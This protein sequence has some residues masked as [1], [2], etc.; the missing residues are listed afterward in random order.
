ML[1]RVVLVNMY[2]KSDKGFTLIELLI[3]IAIIGISLSVAVPL[4]SE[5]L[6]NSRV[7]GAAEA[8]ETTLMYARA[9]AGRQGR[10]VEVV[11]TD[12][13]LDD[14]DPAASDTG[15]NL[16]VQLMERADVNVA[17]VILRSV[18]LSPDGVDAVLVASGQ[19]VLAFNPFGRLAGGGAP[20]F[21]FSAPGS[22]RSM[23][24]S[25]A[26]SGMLNKCTF[27]SEYVGSDGSL[28]AGS[29]C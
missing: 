7:R 28:G 27:S 20:T 16:V 12:D 6:A 19:N 26:V 11:I 25:L 3:V 5:W 9:E 18:K 2:S 22:S 10:I 17:E 4:F 21:L 8:F 24:V 14:L 1:K 23:L 15:R 29:G 13:D